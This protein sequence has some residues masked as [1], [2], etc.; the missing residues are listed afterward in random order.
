MFR[1]MLF[2]IGPT[3]EGRRVP[4]VTDGAHFPCHK[5]GRVVIDEAAGDEERCDGNGDARG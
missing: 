4:Q 5:W 2:T 3:I 1:F